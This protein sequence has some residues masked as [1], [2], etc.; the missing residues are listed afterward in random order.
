MLLSDVD[1]KALCQEKKVTYLR[2]S[3]EENMSQ[4]VQE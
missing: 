4:G 1:S 2:Y 3:R